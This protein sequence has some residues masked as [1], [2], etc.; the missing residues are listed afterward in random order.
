MDISLIPTLIY[1]YLG[2]VTRVGKLVL[3]KGVSELVGGKES[4]RI[5]ALEE[6]SCS[7]CIKTGPK[8]RATGFL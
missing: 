1:I 8:S 5:L 6:D 7:N 4:V 3:W 2:L